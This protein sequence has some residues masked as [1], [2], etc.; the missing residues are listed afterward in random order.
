MRPW[1]LDGNERRRSTWGMTKQVAPSIKGTAFCCPHCGAFT[2]QFWYTAHYRSLDDGAT[3]NVYLTEKVDDFLEGMP[4]D[5]KKD[6]EPWL[7]KVSTGLPSLETYE[8][9]KHG[10]TARLVY[11][12]SL[13][14]CF[15]CRK[16]AIWVHDSLIYPATLSGPAPN[17]DLPDDIAKDYREASSILALSPRG[18]AALLRLC[19]QKLCLH[20]GLPGKN[21]D[22]DIAELV[23]RGL[24]PRIQKALDVVRVTGN[25]AVHPGKM[26]VADD[27]DIAHRLFNLVNLIAERMVSYPKHVDEAYDALPQ[28]AR[29]AIEKRDKPKT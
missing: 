21:I 13:S 1:R 14:G 2:T 3:P 10:Y 26:N 7:R 25:H 5:A 4:D 23:S 29:E 22:S 20:L 24:D 6:I 12:V 27:P 8:E 16:L 19:V 11:N 18:A 15:H 9:N 17:P 28:G